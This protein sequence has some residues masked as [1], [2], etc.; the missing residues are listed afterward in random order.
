MTGGLKARVTAAE[1]LAAAVE[2]GGLPPFESVERLEELLRD[3]GRPDGPET[4][5]ELHRGGELR[6]AW[7]AA[8][9]R[10]PVA[11]ISA[12]DWRL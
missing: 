5:E 1:R 7:L 4:L 6:E 11:F 10:W 12:D 8:G 9:H 2:G 3:F